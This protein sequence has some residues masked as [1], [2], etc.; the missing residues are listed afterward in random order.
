MSG[1]EQ[2]GGQGGLY[3]GALHQE[4]GR[5]H[6]TGL[7]TPLHFWGCWNYQVRRFNIIFKLRSYKY[8]QVD[9]FFGEY[10]RFPLYIVNKQ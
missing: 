7:D 10:T 2:H 4:S 8:K 6:G 3:H 1:V 9:H 5:G